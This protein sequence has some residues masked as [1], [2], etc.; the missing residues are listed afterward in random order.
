MTTF[1]QTDMHRNSVTDI[2]DRCKPSYFLE[3]KEAQ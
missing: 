1:L 2:H 3:A